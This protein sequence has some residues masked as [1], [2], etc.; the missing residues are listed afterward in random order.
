M[1]NQQWPWLVFKVLFEMYLD[2]D[3]LL[4]VDLHACVPVHTHT[5]TH[6]YVHIHTETNTHTHTHPKTCS[7][8]DV[9]SI[10]L[11]DFKATKLSIVLHV[12]NLNIIAY[13]TFPYPLTV[14]L[15]FTSHFLKYQFKSMH[16]LALLWSFY[17]PGLCLSGAIPTPTRQAA[18]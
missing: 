4:W 7:S 14:P 9:T 8:F 3:I 1:I 15:L 6:T 18:G 10:W 16:W 2:L 13:A 5:L 11:L 17:Q 12:R